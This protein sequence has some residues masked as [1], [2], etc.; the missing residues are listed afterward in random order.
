MEYYNK[1]TCYTICNAHGKQNMAYNM[2]ISHPPNPNHSAPGKQR[3]ANE[4][5]RDETV[6][7]VTTGLAFIYNP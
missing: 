4:C 1:L 7:H 5:S 3:T 6:A 2:E